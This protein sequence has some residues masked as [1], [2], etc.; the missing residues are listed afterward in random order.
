MQKRAI[1]AV[2]TL[3]LALSGTATAAEFSTLEERMSRKE[4]DAAGLG[5]LSAEELKALNDW[6]RVNG[7]A[8]GAPVATGKNRT[9]EFYPEEAEREVVEAHIAGNL[10]GWLGK[11]QFKLDNGQVWQQAES[12]MRTDLNLANPQ[13]RIKPMLLGSWLMSIDG[14]NCSLRV[15]RVK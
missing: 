6:L 5:R 4:F 10:T 7:L 15:R 2:L 1:R 9:P 3:A 8:P 14:C 11:T 13:V 12:G